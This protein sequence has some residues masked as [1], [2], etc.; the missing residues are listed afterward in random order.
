MA[1]ADLLKKLFSSY[2]NNDRELFLKIAQEIIADERKKNHALLADELEKV[3]N[4]TRRGNAYTCSTITPISS[5]TDKEAKLVEIIY[6]NKYFDDVVLDFEKTQ[7]FED[8]I[9]QFRNWDI[10]V[11]NGVSP[12]SRLLFY[13]PPGCGKTLCANVLAAEIGIPLMYVRFD[14][15]VSSYLGE[16][17]SNIR[18]VFEMAANDS[19]LILFDEFD[20][21]G[22]SRGDASEHGEI[23]RVVNTFLQQIDC[24]KGHSIIIAATNFEQSLDYAIWRRFDDTVCFNLPTDDEKRNIIAMRLQQ[25]NGPLQ[26]FNVLLSSTNEFSHADVDNMCKAIM[27]KCI[28][29]GKHVYNR[30]D[31]EWAIERQKRIVSLRKIQY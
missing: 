15:L 17:A 10:L 25:F 19:F 31:I 8:V 21:I 16:T 14:A 27:R 23:K 29:E 12:V 26:A 1:R 24:F 22:R 2:T 20:A 4:S 28:L 6:P 11:S 18:R 30:R 7:L 5:S 9:R 3:L 13:G